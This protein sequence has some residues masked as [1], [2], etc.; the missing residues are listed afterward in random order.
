[1]GTPPQRASVIVD[2]HARI[3]AGIR[4]ILSKVPRDATF[5][6]VRMNGSEPNLSDVENAAALLAAGVW[7]GPC[8]LM[9]PALHLRERRAGEP[10]SRP[11]LTSVVISAGLAALPGNWRTGSTTAR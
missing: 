1:M 11:H 9:C 3:A 4:D 2:D 8:V 5:Y 10:S 6:E 7:R